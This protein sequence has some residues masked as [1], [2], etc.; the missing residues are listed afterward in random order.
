VKHLGTKKDW[1]KRK[2][3]R[4]PECPLS[5][6]PSLRSRTS[7][8]ARDARGWTATARVPALGICRRRR[9]AG[10]PQEAGNDPREAGSRGDPARRAVVASRG[11]GLAWAGVASHHGLTR[12]HGA[13]S[14]GQPS[15]LCAGGPA[16]GS[17]P[18]AGGGRCASLE[19]KRSCVPKQEQ[20]SNFQPRVFWSFQPKLN[21]VK[22]T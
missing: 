4:R 18:R 9:Q 16:A 11:R 21:T 22:R 14:R 12:A 13:A 17:R 5:S 20:M 7:P 15:R 8:V 2:R 1:E 3:E 19:C 10:E 6:F